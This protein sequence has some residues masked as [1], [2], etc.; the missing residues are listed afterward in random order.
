MATFPYNQ[1]T[2]QDD[3]IEEV[4]YHAD[5]VTATGQTIGL[6][7]D[8][9]Y[10]NLVKAMRHV[11]NTAPRFAVDKAAADG[12][13][14]APTN[15]NQYTEIPIPDDFSR[16]MDLRLADWKR[17]VFELTD[18]RSSQVRLQYNAKTQADA[19]NPVVA[20]VPD[21]GGASG[22]A[23]WAWPQDSTPTIERFTYVAETAPEGIPQILKE[24]TILKATS[25]TLAADKEEGWQIMDRAY[26][27]I[28]SQIEAGQQ[29]MVRQA[30]QQA[31]ELE[32][33]S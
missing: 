32:D 15:V 11:L 17:E 29:P 12:S 28:I 14:Q 21:P 20:K 13:G 3:L 33:Q 22:E 1:T 25:Y 9:I 27:Q 7:Y 30:I 5:R 8:A 6:N 4:E 2:A 19:Q 18:P 10:N 31:R 24:A 16:F 26:Q 23:L